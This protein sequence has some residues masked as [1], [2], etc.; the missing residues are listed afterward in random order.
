MKPVDQILSDGT[1]V[2]DYDQPLTP[3]E[4]S[5]LF[6]DLFSN[7]SV[8][9]GKQHI[10]YN[11]V[12]ILAAN[13]TYLGHPWPIYK[14]RIQL[15]EYYPAYWKANLVNGLKT[16]FV[17][18]YHYEEHNHRQIL[19]VVFDPGP[20]V[21]RKSHN[22]SAHIQTFD[23]QYAAKTGLYVKTDSNGNRIRVMDVSHFVDFVKQEAL[24][25]NQGQHET[26][27]E[28]I[29]S[30]NAYLK[31]FFNFVPK[32]TWVGV[33][34]I[35]EMRRAEA[36]NWRQ[37]EWQGWYFEYLFRKYCEAHSNTNVAYLGDKK[38]GG[39]DFDIVF[40]KDNWIYGDLKADKENE[41]IIGNKFESFDAVI[42]A[43]NGRVI[44]I[45]LR[46]QAE[47]DKKHGYQTTKFWNKFRD[48]GSK[49]KTVEEIQN[50]YGTRMKYSVTPKS[51]KILSIDKTAY[52]ILKRHPFD[53]GHNSDGKERKPKLQISKDM[54]EAL[55]IYSV[56]C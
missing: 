54:I 5:E 30:V 33:E 36:P 22:S 15:K 37:G 32:K 51:I 44:Y 26:Y 48:E 40:S 39:I 28:L 10:I 2:L 42:D 52:E 6:F 50:G 12:G 29:Q 27:D 34:C 18:I 38:K 11:K 24:E 14:K 23:L 47:L 25:P 4:I 56:A 1:I 8:L 21:E 35:E 20:Y 45:V 13:V 19:F 55:S 43:H 46:Y 41:G 16:L 9:Q 49:Y 17:G 53:Q 7:Q 31:G 3:K